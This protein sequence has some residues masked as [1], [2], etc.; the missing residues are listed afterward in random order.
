M[1]TALLSF[2]DI[3]ELPRLKPA[4]LVSAALVVFAIAS[5]SVVGWR[6]ATAQTQ[7]PQLYPTAPVP[8][9]MLDE[10][11]YTVA[12]VVAGMPAAL[13]FEVL[14]ER[15][16]VMQELSGDGP[17]T[18]L[19]PADNYFDYIP[20]GLPSYSRADEKALAERHVLSHVAVVPTSES[21]GDYV[22]L[23]SDQMPVAVHDDGTVAVGDGF[24]IRGFYAKNGVVYLISRVLVSED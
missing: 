16:G 2:L 24:A 5:W 4:R 11:K 19:V 22:T 13:R 1:P 6:V 10:S 18:I 8:V 21:A 14:L 17:Y 12:Q 15:T 9:Q 20:G 3:P 23:A 7:V